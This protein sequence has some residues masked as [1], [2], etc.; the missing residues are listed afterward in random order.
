MVI[1]G[2]DFHPSW[3]QVS[4]L[5]TETGEMEERKSVQVSGDAERL[6]PVSRWSVIVGRVPRLS[7]LVMESTREIDV[8]L[9]DLGLGPG[10]RRAI[11]EG[12]PNRQIAGRLQVSETAVKACLRQLLAE[13]GVRT[14]SQLVRVALE[15]Y[16]DQ[17]WYV[18][19]ARFAGT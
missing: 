14:R 12:L 19:Q 10:E 6:N 18:F 1:I 15:Q 17:F 13:T 3:Q 16:R 9:L 11:F 2:C 4:W 5:D 8:V 7:L